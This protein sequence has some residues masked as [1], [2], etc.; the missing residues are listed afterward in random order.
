[1]IPQPCDQLE[2]ITMYDLKCSLKKNGKL[3]PYWS[4]S[5]PNDFFVDGI[6]HCLT[7]GQVLWFYSLEFIELIGKIVL[8]FK[9]QTNFLYKNLKKGLIFSLLSLSLSFKCLSLNQ[10]FFDF[11]AIVVVNDCCYWLLH[12][13]CFFIFLPLSCFLALYLVCM[14]SLSLELFS[15]LSIDERIAACLVQRHAHISVATGSVPSSSHTLS[16]GLI[17]HTSGHVP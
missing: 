11:C 3:P 7:R 5:Q 14:L 15:L 2:S 10:I 1:M 12:W 17:P 6:C 16:L 8:S 9:F 4:V 13:F